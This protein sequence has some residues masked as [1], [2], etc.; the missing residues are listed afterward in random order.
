MKVIGN[1]RQPD[2]PPPTC[3]I[4]GHNMYLGTLY[5]REGWGRT[6]WTCSNRCYE[7]HSNSKGGGK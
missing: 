2:Y 3:G 5:D 4:C 6:G 7:K 1:V